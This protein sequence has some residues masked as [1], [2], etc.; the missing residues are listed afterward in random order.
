MY[1][2]L[3]DSA[4]WL[5]GQSMTGK[6]M[7]RQI[8]ISPGTGLIFTLLVVRSEFITQYLFGPAKLNEDNT[9]A[10]GEAYFE[11]Y[12]LKRTILGSGTGQWHYIDRPDFFNI[13]AYKPLSSGYHTATTARS[14]I[15]SSMHKP[16]MVITYRTA[17]NTWVTEQARG[18]SVWS[19]DAN[20]IPFGT[21]G[22]GGTGDGGLQ[23]HVN[24][25]RVHV[26][27]L[28]NNPDLNDITDVG[29]YFYTLMANGSPVKQNGYLQVVGSEQ[30]GIIQ[31]R[32]SV[33]GIDMRRQD[34]EEWDEWMPFGTGENGGDDLTDI[35]KD[36]FILQKNTFFH[37]DTEVN[38]DSIT[39]PGAYYIGTQI[40]GMIYP[41]PNRKILFVVGKAEDAPDY[42]NE[43]HEIAQYLID[44]DGIRFRKKYRVGVEGFNPPIERWDE[45]VP[46]GGV[47]EAP[48]DGK[49]Y[50]RKDGEWVE[51]ND[52]R[53]VILSE[54]EYEDLSGGYDEDTLYF[55]I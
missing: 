49:L 22:S 8:R 46:F 44:R 1:E 53:I 43:T 25:K 4:W 31:L 40:T 34:G 32:Y 15:P 24:N 7:V 21:G 30:T 13:D 54:E 26:Q 6:I 3:N 16:G 5:N 9:F 55:I 51:A 52:K 37:L 42:L 20:W 11:S 29:Y 33:Y 10:D 38:L 23:E 28:G 14:A 47:P 35:K 36:V 45:W 39:Y 41:V 2:K 19:Q 27:N 18:T 48:Q 12:I 50:A 17:A